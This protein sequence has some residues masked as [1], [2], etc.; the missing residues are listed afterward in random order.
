MFCLGFDGP[1]WGS[2]RL[3]KGCAL[4]KGQ[5][6]GQLPVRRPTSGPWKWDVSAFSRLVTGE[7]KKVETIGNRMFEGTF[8][9]LTRFVAAFGALIGVLDRGL[10]RC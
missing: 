3:C 4:F 10:W 9:W 2:R 7:Q 6:P 8:G 1:K 5:C